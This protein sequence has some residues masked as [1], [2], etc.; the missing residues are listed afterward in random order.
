[1]SDLDKVVAVV[2]PEVGM[3]LKTAKLVITLLAGLLA[4]VVIG[5]VIWKVFF[6]GGQAQRAHDKV[7]QQ[8][9]T[10]LGKTGAESGKQAVEITVKNNTQAAGIDR[11]TQRAIHDLLKAP[12]ANSPVDPNLAALARRAICMRVS[13][14]SL[15]E[16]K[17]MLRP[18]P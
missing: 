9:N 12:G 14:A 5:F 18:G 13:A 17:Q 11:D 7:E 1:M 15:D 10:G 16:C 3:S 8:V 6:A 4:A 2:A